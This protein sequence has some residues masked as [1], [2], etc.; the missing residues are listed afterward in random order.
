[1]KHLQALPHHSRK[2]L[3]NL[4]T[5]TSAI[6]VGLFIAL[7][8]ISALPTAYA[9]TAPPSGTPAT[10]S[11][12]PLPTVQVNGIVWAQ[13]TVGN[14]V[15]ATG[16]FT[17]ARP[18]GVAVGGAGSVTR[19]NLLAYN[20]TTGQLIGTFNFSLTGSGTVEGRAIAA[21]PD[22]KYLFI[23]GKFAAVNGQA[24][25]NFATI[26]LLTNS[27]RSN[28]A[29]PN[30]IV[31]S[32]A[33]TNSRVYV[34][35]DFTTAG[36]QSRNRLAAYDIASGSLVSDWNPSVTTVGVPGGTQ[37]HS[38]VIGNT[39]GYLVV[40]GYFNRINGSTYYSTGAVRLDNGQNV[41]WASQSSS[42]PIRSQLKANAP[43]GY[44]AVISSL[45]TDGN[46]IYLT[47]WAYVSS[48]GDGTFEGRAAINPN[49]GNIIWINDCHGDTYGAF[50]IGQVLYSAGH[51]HDCSLIGA[52][53][54]VAPRVSWR[55]VAEAT[56]RDPNCTNKHASGNYTDFFGWPCSVQLNWYPKLNTGSVSGSSQAAWSVTGNASYVSYGGE[57][58]KAENIAQQ[59][60]VRYAI[61][62]LAPNRYGP[63]AYST[64]GISAPAA[65]ASGN[66]T[67]TYR[68]TSD[69]DNG[70]LTY[71]AYRCGSST[72]VHT[73]VI[74]TRFWN[75]PNR[76]FTDSGL[77]SGSVQCYRL[78]VAD[79]FGNSV[80]TTSP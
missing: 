16:R 78:T 76:S 32:I 40:G 66:T 18:A 6:V 14:T 1:M 45:S 9:D 17:Q 51:P 77:T 26:D 54:E 63:A 57:F 8:G 75:T 13:A 42:Y 65:N 24:R 64:S 50:P 41:P 72:P 25:S 71:S 4:Y 5:A 15:Y 29:G 80:S 20:I 67:V 43:A 60:L 3:H 69:R 37:V 23:G 30:A 39:Q 58:T 62:N 2:K 34:G 55:A 12:D 21:S 68:T 31:R 74:S 53:P 7:Q 19:N 79:P 56:D 10:V 73:A 52:F 38:M 11:V 22:G 36:G 59:G 27:L 70:L 49:D 46:Q 28:A 33:A 47:A 44:A 48:Y 61:S 35:G